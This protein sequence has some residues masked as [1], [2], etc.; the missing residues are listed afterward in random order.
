ML[1][2]S[3][4]LSLVVATE[5]VFVRVSL[6]VGVQPSYESKIRILPLNLNV[7]SNVVELRSS[8]FVYYTTRFLLGDDIG[9]RRQLNNILDQEL[10]ESLLLL[11]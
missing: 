1:S 5:Q 6:T 2:T 3:S 9:I 10:L 11:H 7:I 4:V 8:V